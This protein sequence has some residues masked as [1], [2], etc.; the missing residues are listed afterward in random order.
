[1][2][3][4]EPAAFMSIPPS[5]RPSHLTR[6]AWFWAWATVGGI[7]AVGLISL[8]PVALAPATVA[9]VAMA[10]SRNGRQ[11]LFGLL[12]GA[13]LLALFVAYVQRA[14]PGVTCWHTATAS[15]CDQHLDPVPW[16]VA[17]VLL[18]VA[19]VTGQIRR[20]R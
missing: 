17:G 16:L 19:A 7:A 6:C 1:M 10:L 12:A 5:S 3:V 13:G 11:S 18:V 14:G 20:G 2:G 4:A 8:G 9:G 15:G